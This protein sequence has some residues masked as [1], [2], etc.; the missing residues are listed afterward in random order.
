MAQH[1]DLFRLLRFFCTRKG[2][3]TA[4]A[5]ISAWSVVGVF[6]AGG[7]GLVANEIW[8][9]FKAMRS[10]IQM[11][12]RHITAANEREAAMR[13][14]YADLKQDAHELRATV[15]DHERRLYRIEGRP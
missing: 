9:E 15:N 3:A 13:A 2:I 14:G 10:G 11:I 7:V 6:F 8:A 4:G 12:E 5:L 1:R